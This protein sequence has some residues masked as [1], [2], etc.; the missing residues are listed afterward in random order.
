[1]TCSLDWCA[2]ASLIPTPGNVA[3]LA[4]PTHEATVRCVCFV[5]STM[6]HSGMQPSQIMIIGRA[7]C[8]MS[9]FISSFSARQT[10]TVDPF[11]TMLISRKV[12]FLT[13]FLRRAR[14]WRRGR[15]RRLGHGRGNGDRSIDRSIHPSIHRSIARCIDRSID[16]SVW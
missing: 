6:M 5:T 2:L 3:R 9:R 14:R 7:D 11:T 4:T 8:Q 10:P 1:M 13:G 12:G 16:R 15:R